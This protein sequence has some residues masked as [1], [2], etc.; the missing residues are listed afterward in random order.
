MPRPKQDTHRTKCSFTLD[1]DI[2]ESFKF[3]AGDNLSRALDELIYKHLVET[4][5]NS[6]Y[7]YFSRKYG[8]LK[9]YND[10]IYYFA[11][12]ED[13]EVIEE[14]GRHRTLLGALQAYHKLIDSEK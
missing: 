9:L 14:L 2:L 1:K 12:V 11:G 8:F 3:I 10:G 13:S 7:I 5:E 4:Y 6:N